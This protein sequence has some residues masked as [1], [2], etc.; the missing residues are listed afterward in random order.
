M[1][2]TKGDDIAKKIVGTNLKKYRVQSGL[3]YRALATLA[4]TDSSQ[5]IRIEKEQVNCS[6]SFLFRL[7]AALNIEPEQLIEK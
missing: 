2:K 7:A 6:I 4:E 1:A 3:S 5:L